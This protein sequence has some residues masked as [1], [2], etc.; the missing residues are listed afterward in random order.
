M[1]R[2]VVEIQRG[3]LVA[4]NFSG[5]KPPPGPPHL[6]H[7]DLTASPPAAVESLAQTISSSETQSPQCEPHTPMVSSF[8]VST[9]AFDVVTNF[10]QTT[11]THSTL[12][13]L[14]KNRDLATHVSQT[15]G[16]FSGEMMIIML[17]CDYF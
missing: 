11:P 3:L 9:L 14:I 8:D 4:H 6:M 16:D 17:L 1:I 15:S 7:F 10:T 2:D 5:S 13:S 12:F